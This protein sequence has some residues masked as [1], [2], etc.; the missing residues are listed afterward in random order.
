MP[1]ASDPKFSCPKC[2]KRHTWKPQLAGK[3]AKCTCGAAITVPV[4]E[5]GDAPDD[6]Y[7]VVETPRPAP[8]PATPYIPPVAQPAAAAP[9]P[10]TYHRAADKSEKERDRFRE[11]NLISP[12]RDIYAPIA[13][14]V[15]GFFGLI[16][17]ASYET[18][19][20]T[21]AMVLASAIW[22]LTTLVKTV[23]L[24]GMAFVYAPQ[25][26]IGF[27]DVK[28]AVLKFAAIIMFTDAAD[29]W[30]WEVLTA[31]RPNRISL[32]Q[33]GLSLIVAAL[34]ISALCHILFEMDTEETGMFALPMAVVSQVIGFL[35]RLGVIALL[36]MMLNPAL[37]AAPAGG[38][39]GAGP[40]AIAPA[41]AAGTPTATT[42]PGIFSPDDVP[43]IKAA[44]DKVAIRK[45]AQDQQIERR[46][47]QGGPMLKDALQW[48]SAPGVGNK[49][50]VP[51][52]VSDLAAA[53]ADSIHLEIN[54]RARPGKLYARLPDSKSARSA[55]L[56][57]H[58]AY[59][60][61]HEPDTDPTTIKDQGQ[62]FLEIELKQ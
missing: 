48:V 47:T 34:L 9:A 51:A 43:D 38:G 10:L 1:S 7:D 15:I 6:L 62:Q 32:R 19:G 56:K 26:G 8:A 61:K 13:I 28:T 16:A 58:R 3:R 39:G 46:I 17:W 11:D 41:P 5:P 42:G 49:G 4:N 27:G 2:G 22:G 21:F 24:I 50:D 45:T 60:K 53:G 20:S 37:P 55:C 44:S 25:L 54:N 30:L 35:L 31:G 59:V 14:L 23:I 57:V 33:I 29:L 36:E 40:T 18:G 12:A 52:L